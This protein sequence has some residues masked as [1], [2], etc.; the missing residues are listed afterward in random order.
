MEAESRE[1]SLRDHIMK[2]NPEL[3][4]YRETTTLTNILYHPPP[5]QPTGTC[6]M[7]CIKLVRISLS[8]Q[9]RG[10]IHFAFPGPKQKRQGLGSP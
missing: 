7:C 9:Q 8:G 6:K 3:A 5:S 1:A 4:S 2:A 10:R